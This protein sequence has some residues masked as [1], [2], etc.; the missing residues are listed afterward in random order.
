[1]MF[2]EKQKRELRKLYKKSLE[3][4][5]EVSFGNGA[6]FASPKT[7]RYPYV[8]PRD[9]S[10][11]IR[12]LCEIGELEK[13]KK[14]LNFLMS[15]Q[16]EI[17]EWSQRYHKDGSIASYRPPQVDC[18]G[19]VLYTIR[20]YF[21]TSNDIT[22]IK[23]W[24]KNIKR[25]VSFINYQFIPETNLI[26]SLNGI[27]EWP[28]LEAGYDIWVN[29]ACYAGVR[30]AYKIAKSLGEEDAASEYRLLAH[31]LN[32]GIAKYLVRDNRYIKLVHGRRIVKDADISEM[33]MYITGMTSPNDLIMKNT[34]RSIIKSLWND[35]FW[36][37]NRYLKKYG[38][39]GR[40]NGGYGPYSMYTAWVGQY[41]LD[42]KNNFRDKLKECVLWFVKYNREGLIPEHISDKE[43]FINWI[44]Q[45]KRVGRYKKEGREKQAEE[46]MRSKEYLEKDIVYWVT[47]LTW[48][49]AE[50]ML[51]YK[52]LKNKKL[53]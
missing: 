50:F 22:S 21:E 12:V 36:G 2:S 14:S 18:N 44:E 39:P 45:A 7:Q 11:I 17:G 35:K 9:A 16:R 40:N 13:A 6:I 26:F 20:K 37:I 24:W 31:N 5:D 42:T 41:L 47:P 28:P 23:R 30:A 48:A 43:E 1:M 49:H 3:V 15:V 51:L 38:E 34:V 10:L 32:N 33:G 8:Y 4:L 46:V 53:I 27:H 19:L 29:S 25:G 52:K